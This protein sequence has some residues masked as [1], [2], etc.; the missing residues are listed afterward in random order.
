M[1]GLGQRTQPKVVDSDELLPAVSLD[2]VL[3]ELTPLESA[4]YDSGPATESIEALWLI[5]RGR[6]F[7]YALFGSSPESSVFGHSELLEIKFSDNNHYFEI[8]RN[9]SRTPLLKEGLPEIQVK[10]FFVGLEILRGLSA[11]LKPDPYLSAT[12]GFGDQQRAVLPVRGISTVLARAKA[13]PMDMRIHFLRCA[14]TNQP[15]MGPGLELPYAAI[16]EIETTD[17]FHALPSLRDVFGHAIKLQMAGI[18]ISLPKRGSKGFCA[19]TADFLLQ[20]FPPD[21]SF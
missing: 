13:D 8:L 5:R 11:T 2:N 14:D 4:F 18:E 17:P 15:Y 7:Y 19:A 21:V 20:Q 16:L 9:G 12:F 3:I 10:V 1:T 6:R